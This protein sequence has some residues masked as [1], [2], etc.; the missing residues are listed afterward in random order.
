MV[1]C[2]EH[3]AIDVEGGS[4][5]RMADSALDLCRVCLGLDEKSDGRVPQ[6][7][8]RE[9]IKPGC[10]YGWLPHARSEV[11]GAKWSALGTAGSIERVG[12][13]EIGHL[14]RGVN[15]ASPIGLS[16]TRSVRPRCRS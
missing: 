10:A 13:G 16:A 12:D 11:P 3:V 6:V 14:G 7:M 8:K 5:R 2:V 9:P 1:G 15:L 4:D